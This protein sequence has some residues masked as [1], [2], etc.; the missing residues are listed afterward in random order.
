MLTAAISTMLLSRSA[1]PRPCRRNKLNE[2]SP[3]EIPFSSY[4]DDVIID[5]ISIS[6]NPPFRQRTRILRLTNRYLRSGDV[7]SQSP[8]FLSSPSLSL[9]LYFRRAIRYP[10]RSH[11]KSRANLKGRETRDKNAGPTYIPL[12]GV[13]RGPVKTTT[14][15]EP[16]WRTVGRGG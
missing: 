10:L 11:C 16:P 4:H 3:S 6:T 15:E 5:Q 2:I 9:F 13:S 1:S 7:L 12:G 14:I 8:L